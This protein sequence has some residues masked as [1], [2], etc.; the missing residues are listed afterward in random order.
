M[1]LSGRCMVEEY[2]KEH[3][4]FEDY[5]VCRQCEGKEKFEGITTVVGL[6]GVGYA[7]NSRKMDTKRY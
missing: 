4:R 2:P 5:F 1:R 6:I 7:N 3:E